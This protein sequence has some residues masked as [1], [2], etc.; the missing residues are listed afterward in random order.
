MIYSSCRRTYP[1][2]LLSPHATKPSTNHTVPM[3]PKSQCRSTKPLFPLFPNAN[4]TFNNP[5]DFPDML[6][7]FNSVQQCSERLWR[8]FTG[9][10]FHSRFSTWQPHLVLQNCRNQSSYIISKNRWRLCL[11]FPFILTGLN[12]FDQINKKKIF[13]PY[14]KIPSTELLVLS[15]W[16]LMMSRRLFPFS[17]KSSLLPTV[18]ISYLS[19]GY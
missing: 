9:H 15:K 1:I 18:S 2:G 17:E 14:E 10:P 6:M 12:L 3:Q 11:C 7:T 5:V 19:E 4:H 8:W 13:S 16:L